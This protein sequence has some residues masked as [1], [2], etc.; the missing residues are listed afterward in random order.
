MSII[1]TRYHDYVGTTTRIVARV[2]HDTAV[3]AC[4]RFK[5]NRVV[6]TRCGGDEEAKTRRVEEEIG[7][8]VVVDDRATTVWA[9]VGGRVG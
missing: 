7:N 1:F 8:V 9:K 5:E 4:R 3:V 2:S 6:E